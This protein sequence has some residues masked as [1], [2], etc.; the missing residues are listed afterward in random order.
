MS[1]RYQVLRYLASPVER[2]NVSFL[3]PANLTRPGG[4]RVRFLQLYR[5]QATIDNRPLSCGVQ[6]GYYLAEVGAACG[7][8]M[9][10]GMVGKVGEMDRE[11][12]A[13]WSFR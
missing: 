8:E 11:P 3:V 4:E 2:V 5:P 6:T 10:D 9:G 1:H 7:M 13:L 12:F